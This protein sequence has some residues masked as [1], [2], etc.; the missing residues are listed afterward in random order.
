MY[1]F[2]YFDQK[3]LTTSYIML[4]SNFLKINAVRKM[5]NPIILL[6]QNSRFKHLQ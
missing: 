4:N 6:H 5:I 2:N 3:S 1:F